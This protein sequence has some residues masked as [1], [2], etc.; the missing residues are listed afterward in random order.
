[1]RALDHFMEA[2]GDGPEREAFVRKEA[3][4]LK[5]SLATFGDLLVVEP[6]GR[7]Y[8]VEFARTPP[9]KPLTRLNDDAFVSFSV[10]PGGPIFR[11]EDLDAFAMGMA[12]RGKT[13][14][15]LKRLGL[16][17]RRGRVT[18]LEKA[19]TALI[20]WFKKNEK[21]LRGVA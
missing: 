21:Q 16:S 12:D 17:F 18:T 13:K 6:G 19:T 10:G 9:T 1:M 15:S 14:D 3:E 4:R 11:A 7:G 8:K 5:R 20:K 2:V